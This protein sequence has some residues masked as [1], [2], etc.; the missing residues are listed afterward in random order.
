MN[1]IKYPSEDYIS[2]NPIKIKIGG[3][4]LKPINYHGTSD[5][6]I[7][8]PKLKLY[9]GVEK[10]PNKNLYYIR[11]ILEEKDENFFSFIES[12]ETLITTRHEDTLL[13][14]Q[15][16]YINDKILFSIK[17]PYRYK[18]FECSVFSK[19]NKKQPIEYIKHNKKN[20]IRALI[21]TQGMRE[22]DNEIYC[23]WNLKEIKVYD[24]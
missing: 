17:L 12:I 8:T 11:C 22:K 6:Y 20:N 19:N 24:F 7:Q 2:L 10:I 3:T 5:F 15:L 18:N 14:S 4:F 9:D 23:T 13:F 21:Q 16:E 1:I